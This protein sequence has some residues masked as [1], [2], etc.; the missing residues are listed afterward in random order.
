MQISFLSIS[1]TLIEPKCS[2][3][4][5]FD[6]ICGVQCTHWYPRIAKY[7]CTA[8]G[9]KSLKDSHFECFYEVVSLFS[10]S[11]VV[12]QTVPCRVILCELRIYSSKVL[13]SLLK[14]ENVVNVEN[15]KSF[16]YI[17]ACT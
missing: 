4:F 7:T 2:I 3:C 11:L 17:K 8:S 5:S 9:F 10:G 16:I 12:T 6:K 13:S 15:N 1:V 14:T